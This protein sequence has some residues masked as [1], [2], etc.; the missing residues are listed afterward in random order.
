MKLPGWRARVPE[1]GRPADRAAV[2]LAS[3]GK[4]FSEAAVRAAVV[5]AGGEPVRV[6]SIAKIYGTALGLQHPGLLP[7]KR[8]MAAQEEIIQDA[9]DKIEQAGGRAKGEMVAT[10]DPAKTFWRAAIRYSVRHVVLDPN[11]SS[12]LR[13]LVE[14]DPASSLRRRLG[15]D[16]EVEVVETMTTEP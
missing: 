10:R 1:V 12:W 15:S 3:T 14:G 2:L 7:S 8:E 11:E 5:A 4:P 13:R 6:L 16:V 9:V